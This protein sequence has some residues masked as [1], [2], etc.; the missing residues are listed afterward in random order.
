MRDTKSSYTITSTHETVATSSAIESRP[1]V[2]LS[3]SVS[4]SKCAHTNKTMKRNRGARLQTYMENS[5]HMENTHSTARGSHT[6]DDATGRRVRR[7]IAAMSP[8]ERSA[9]KRLTH[10]SRARQLARLS[11]AQRKALARRTRERKRATYRRKMRAMTPAQR[12]AFNARKNLLRR[13]LRERRGDGATRAMRRSREEC[14][15][16]VAAY[17]RDDAKHARARKRVVAA[18]Q[19][20]AR[21]KE[22]AAKMRE[23]ARANAC[24]EI[25]SARRVRTTR[26]QRDTSSRATRCR[27]KHFSVNCFAH[28]KPYLEIVRRRMQRKKEWILRGHSHF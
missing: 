15:R 27:W 2:I 4:K 6:I 25:T 8:S 7:P 10:E 26:I 18:A 11:P 17:V 23:K 13:S 12:D 22:H 5:P 24:R 1:C 16:C 21:A 3:E 14:A 19:K 9:A 20:Q 28:R